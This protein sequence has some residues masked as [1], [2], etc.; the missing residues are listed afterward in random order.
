MAAKTGTYTLIASTTL[1]ATSNTITFSSIPATYTDLVLVAQY[2]RSGGTGQSC[3]VRVNGDSGNNYS[4]THLSGNGTS[5]S[6]GRVSNTNLAAWGPWVANTSTTQNGEV[7][8][9]HIMDYANT[10]TYKTL[11]YRSGAADK[12]TESGVNLWRSTAAINSITVN[13][14]SP[15]VFQSGNTFKLYGIEAGNL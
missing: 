14:D 10:T 13:I 5:A 3:Y 7:G 9:M 4:F 6:S 12:A 11:L 1:S 2:S 8:I 15:A